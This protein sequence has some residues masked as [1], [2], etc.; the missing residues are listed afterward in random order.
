MGQSENLHF[1]FLISHFLITGKNNSVRISKKATA[2]V[3]YWGTTQKGTEK[4]KGTIGCVPCY[5]SK[6][7]S[8]MNVYLFKI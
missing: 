3:I 7:C 4:R 1:Y 2:M 8:F 5:T 6:V